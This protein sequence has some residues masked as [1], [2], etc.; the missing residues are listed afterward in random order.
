MSNSRHIRT[1]LVA[2]AAVFALSAVAVSSASAALPEFTSF[3]CLEKSGGFGEYGTKAECENLGGVE[4]AGGKWK[5]FYSNSLVSTSGAGTLE[6]VSGETVKCKTDSDSGL[7]S[8]PK[9]VS[10]VYVTFKGCKAI[11]LGFL[12]VACKT[13][14][15]ASE[16]IVTNELEGSIGYTNASKKEVA[17]KLEPVG[18][19][20]A[21]F[22]CAGVTLEVRG[23][24]YGKLTPVNTKTTTYKLVFK[25]SKG[26]QEITKF[27][28]GSSNETLETSKAGEAFEESAEATEDT[29]TASEEGE[30]KA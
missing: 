11:V 2:L 22:E 5:R 8:G 30:I 3:D 14:G 13:T 6:T 28:G 18:S 4:T 7:I 20:F 23:H 9:S 27:E 15:A 16:E 25:Q 19:L 29:V 26:K 24:V 10:D 17:L 12:E 21:T 1:L